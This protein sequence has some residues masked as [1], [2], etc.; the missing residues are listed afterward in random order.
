MQDLTDGR[1]YTIDFLVVD[2]GIE[3]VEHAKNV[4]FRVEK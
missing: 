2:R 4:R 3:F 1:S